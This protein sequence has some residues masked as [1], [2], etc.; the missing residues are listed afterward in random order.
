MKRFYE[1]VETRVFEPGTGVGIAAPPGV[2][3]EILLDG[4]AVRTPAKAPLCVPTQQLADAIS[5]EW[6]DQADE[7]DSETM[8]MTRLACTAIDRASSQRM[9]VIDEL[10][11]YGETDLLCYV[12]T[13]P[14]ELVRRQK[15]AW[16]PILDWGA[17]NYDVCLTVTNGLL[18]VAQATEDLDRLR[19]VIAGYDDFLLTALHVATSASGSILLGLAL[20]EGRLDARAVWQ[21]S[22]VDELYQAELWGEDKDAAD[23]RSGLFTTIENAQHL[24]FL[25]K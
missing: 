10:V 9:P 2:T 25:L 13:Q 6:F 8:P 19:H 23:R 18:P 4:R 1:T 16:R 22:L 15:A 21:A 17:E 7:I 24:V 3:Y 20:I 5:K 14:D 12:A 11:R